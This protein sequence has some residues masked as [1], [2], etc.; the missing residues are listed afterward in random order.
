MYILFA[1]PSSFM[2]LVQIVRVARSLDD[3]STGNNREA[4]IA[5]MAITTSNSMRVKAADARRRDAPGLEAARILRFAIKIIGFFPDE[6]MSKNYPC[7]HTWNC[8][9]CVCGHRPHI[10]KRCVLRVACCVLALHPCG[11][12]FL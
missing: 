7:S 2:L 6:C 5:M 8:K 3:V 1:K 4:R 12:N 10:R 9:V 11:M